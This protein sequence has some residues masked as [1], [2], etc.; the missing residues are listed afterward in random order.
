MIFIHRFIPSP[1]GRLP[2]RAAAACLAA[3]LLLGAGCTTS[4]VKDAA[5]MQANF[6]YES[7]NAWD[8]P[9]LSEVRRVAV[10]PLYFPEVREESLRGYQ[11][12]LLTELAATRRFEVV[13]LSRSH[14]EDHWGRADFSAARP[15]PPDFLE[16]IRE[17]WDADAVLF[18]EFTA[19]RPYK[20]IHIGFRYRLASTYSGE[21][22]LAFD[23]VFDSG[24]PAVAV[25]ARRYHSG[26]E[27][28]AYP[29]DNSS[30]VLNSPLSFFKY[31]S[32]EAVGHATE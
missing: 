3:V 11:N 26:H 17:D 28:L 10:L 15:L 19:F 4:Q 20:P 21:T 1:A 13:A 31:V 12:I 24:V 25:A 5:L 23:D 22:L 8:A 9:G 30:S 32:A 7:G 2:T 18:P 16:R 6:P 27:R 14:L 29:L